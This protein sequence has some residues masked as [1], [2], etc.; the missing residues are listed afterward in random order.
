MRRRAIA[1]PSRSRQIIGLLG[2]TVLLPAVVLLLGVW[3]QQRGGGD[4]AELDAQRLRLNGIVEQ[5]EAHARR[6]S[7]PDYSI[8]FRRD[9]KLYGGPLAVAEARDARDEVATLT[10]VMDLRRMLPPVVIW[11]AGLATVLSIVMLV[12]G[13]VLGRLGRTSREVLVRGFAL[14]R[15]VLPAVLAAQVVLGTIAF[16]S[17]VVFEAAVLA[18]PGIGS[19]EVKMLGM[20]AVAVLASLY[21]AGTALAGLRRTMAAFE[22]DPLPILGRPVTPSEAPGLWRLVTGLA[23][24]LGALKPDSIVVGLTE[25][26][27]VSAGPKVLSP[28]GD[29]FSD[30][31]LYVPLPYLPLLRPNQVASIIGHELAH[32]AGGDTAYSLRFL[33]IYAGVERSLDAVATAGAGSGSAFGLLSAPMRLGVFV[34][35][36]FHRAVRHWS[37]EREFAA[38]AAGAEPT[39]PDAAAQALLR[40]GAVLPRI[41]ETLN[42]ASE[43]PRA[44]PDDLVAAV[45]DNAVARGLDDPAAYLGAEQTHP[46]DTHPPTRERV[47]RLGRDLTPDLLSAAAAAPTADGLHGLGAY[48]ADPA[49]L[50]RAATS[51]FLAVVRQNEEAY[52]AHLEAAASDVAPDD[53]VL[54]VNMRPGGYLLLALGAFLLGTCAFL[55]SA[56][57]PGTKAK[58]LW[59]IT[60]A[61]GT[62]GAFFF[63]LGLY[64]WYLGERPFLVLRPEALT[65]PGLDRSIAWDEIAD[66]DITLGNSRV[67][68]R[69][70]LGPEAALPQR[71]TGGRGV[72]LD[73]ERRIITIKAGL[74][75]KMKVQAYAEL[76]GRYRRAAEARR[77]LAERD[78]AARAESVAATS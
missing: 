16:V 1:T 14:M 57:V 35:D 48:F 29:T 19:G 28:S 67:V 59:I 38:D 46:T 15:H 53:Q 70:L 66:L 12:A 68:T 31:T 76:I 63:G 56:G 71:V 26:F 23:D 4:L 6:S 78:A 44:A 32:F 60:G 77:L 10:K 21:V 58:E 41:V 33:P 39:S 52:H 36:Q 73:E 75:R 64:Y 43:N 55:L 69:L 51:D 3:E 62:L 30:R 42:E 18:Q 74:P 8:G 5:L 24:R 34:M 25:G 9:G 40:T 37:R 11:A 49:S 65:I 7:Q 20:A 13:A 50:C 47:T 27:F 17:A 54:A 22:P 61:G 45:L 72:A 2:S